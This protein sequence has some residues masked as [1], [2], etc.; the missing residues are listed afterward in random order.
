MTLNCLIYIFAANF[1]LF[2]QPKTGTH[3][4]IP[5]LRELTHK[6]VYWGRDYEDPIGHLNSVWESNQKQGSF[7][8]LHAPYSAAIEAHLIEKKCVSFFIKRDPRDQIV[9][10][11]NHYKHI[12]WNDKAVELIP[13]DDERL[14]YMIEGQLRACTLSFMGWLTSPVCCVLDFRKL[15]GK[16]GGAATEAEA[17][18]ELRKVATILRLTISDNHLR[19]VYKKHLGTGWNFFKGKVGSWRDYFNEA[20]KAAAKREIGDLLIELGY[21]KD[22]DW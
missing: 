4:L 6:S 11:L 13:T 3:L 14:L 5:I 16:F 18:E 21:E 8:H 19:R 20:H 7:L 17:I 10:L 9:S 2:T 15:V 22:Y 12:N 1:V